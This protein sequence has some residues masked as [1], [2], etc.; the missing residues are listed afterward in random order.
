MAE[1]V[2]VVKMFSYFN[3]MRIFFYLFCDCSILCEKEFLTFF[4]LYSAE[5]LNISNIAT[6]KR[7]FVIYVKIFDYLLT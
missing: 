7:D 6:F 2:P 4:I 1:M 3:S 5:Q